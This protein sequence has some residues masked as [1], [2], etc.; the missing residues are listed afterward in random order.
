MVAAATISKIYP[1]RLRLRTFCEF[2]KS[3]K[4]QQ[5]FSWGRRGGRRC[6]ARREE[7]CA[8]VWLVGAAWLGGAGR[9]V[10]GTGTATLEAR[11]RG[12]AT[13]VVPKHVRWVQ[14]LR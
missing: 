11:G 10:V 9:F 2:A 13:A 6:H 4:S 3:N 1:E 7:P 8:V 5:V 14:H 12:A